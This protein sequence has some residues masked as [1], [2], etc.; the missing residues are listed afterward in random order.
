[1]AYEFTLLLSNDRICSKCDTSA[2]YILLGTEN[3]FLGFFCESHGNSQKSVL[4]SKYQFQIDNRTPGKPYRVKRKY[5]VKP[6]V[7]K[8]IKR[9]YSLRLRKKK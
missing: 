5:S 1:M 7:S 2:T 3:E 8:P 4:E 9:H 6:H